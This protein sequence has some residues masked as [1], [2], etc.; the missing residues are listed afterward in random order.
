MWI[1]RGSLGGSNLDAGAEDLMVDGAEARRK[2]GAEH[3]TLAGAH[4]GGRLAAAAVGE[5][6]AR[7]MEGEAA[8]AGAGAQRDEAADLT[9]GG[10]VSHEHAVLDRLDLL[11][12]GAFDG[13]SVSQPAVGGGDEALSAGV[14][15]C[16]Q[17]E[18]PCVSLRRGGWTH[19][20]GGG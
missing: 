10:G 5:S 8:G 20:G 19:D 6:Q 7:P 17:R 11:R 1:E 12:D 9:G 18:H 2:P 15:F 16:G 3:G 4:D 14:I 13:E